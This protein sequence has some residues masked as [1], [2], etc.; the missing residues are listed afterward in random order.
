METG[1][2]P[3]LV[4]RPL[5]SRPAGVPLLALLHVRSL[6]PALGLPLKT[7]RVAQQEYVMHSTVLIDHSQPMNIHQMIKEAAAPV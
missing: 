7:E 4:R 6:V 1:P 3:L 5:K 2:S